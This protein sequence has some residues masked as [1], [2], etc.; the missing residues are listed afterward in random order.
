MD[1]SPKPPP[2]AFPSGSVLRETRF[3]GG[4][5]HIVALGLPRRLL[6]DAYVRLMGMRWSQLIL[7]FIAGFLGFN[8]LFAVLYLLVP[9]SLGDSSRND[10]PASPLDAF[11]FS[12]QTVA[13]IGYGVLYPKS[14]YANILVT[15]EIMAGV[16]GF[17]MGN[18]LMFA[19]FSRP[20][21]RIMFSRIAVVAPH[22]G[23]PTLMFRAA[24]QRHNLILEAHVRVALARVEISSE[25]RAM[26]RFRDLAI[27]RRD[28][29]TF[30]LSW[31]VMHPIDESSPLYG[32]SPEEVAGSDITIIVVMNG[33]DESFGQPVYAR[34]I[35][36]ARDIVWGSHFA[37]IIGVAEDGRPTIDYG[38]FHSVDEPAPEPASVEAIEQ[39]GA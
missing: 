23:V 17:A 7:L 3:T 26:R 11:F 28:N 27:E 33:A 24:N 32:L 4:R 39:R 9:G 25:G 18:G 19:R 35:Y 37:D 29:L 2:K 5:A 6:T 20:T 10:G 31:T 34:H 15:L 1:A 8:I 14:L 30:F 16:F 38:K 12:V 22:N 36:A 13:T 21:A